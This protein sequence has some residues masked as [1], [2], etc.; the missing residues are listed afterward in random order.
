MELASEKGVPRLSSIM[1]SRKARTADVPS[2]SCKKW[3]QDMSH[4]LEG[5]R[6]LSDEE[7]L[8]DYGSYQGTI[9]CFDMY[10]RDILLITLSS[11]EEAHSVLI[12][13]Q[14]PY[15]KQMERLVSLSPFKTFS[16]VRIRSGWSHT[17]KEALELLNQLEALKSFSVRSVGLVGDVLWVTFDDMA[18]SPVKMKEK[19]MI[20]VCFEHSVAGGAKGLWSFLGGLVAMAA[21]ETSIDGRLSERGAM[22]EQVEASEMSTQVRINEIFAAIRRPPDEMKPADLESMLTEVTILFSRLSIAASAMTRDYVKAEA[23]LRA[24]RSLFNRWSERSVDGRVPNSVVEL[25]SYESAIAPFKDFA[26]RVDALR[27]QLNT[28]LDAVRT[29]LGVRQQGLT[30]EEQKSS[31]EQLVRLVNLQEILHKVEILIVAVYMTEM[32]KV[33]FE[34]FAHEHAGYYTALFIPA[35]LVLSVLIGKLLHKGH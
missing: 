9:R 7:L 10:D 25:D 13:D 26:E 16:L 6:L 19:S 27:A 28:I 22:L 18:A 17:Q 21:I 15:D 12:E 24:L 35:A 31:K 14:E 2:E 3:L 23:E 33:V 20:A 5:A 30:L 29:Y 32:A 11:R 8:V 34:A 1:V 4:G